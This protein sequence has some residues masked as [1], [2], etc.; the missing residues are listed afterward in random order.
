[1][2][3]LLTYGEDGNSETFESRD[4]AAVGFVDM[5]PLSDRF[6]NIVADQLAEGETIEM[7]GVTVRLW[8]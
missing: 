3:Y 2:T 5:L 1:M 8:Y 4:E 7:N 6:Y